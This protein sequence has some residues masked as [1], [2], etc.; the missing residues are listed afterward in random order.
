MAEGFLRL[1]RAGFTPDPPYAVGQSVGM[2]IR[3]RNDGDTDD[4]FLVVRDALAGATLFTFREPFAAGEQ[5]DVLF[6]VQVP[7]PNNAIHQWVFEAGHLGPAGDA[8][9]TTEIVLAAVGSL[10]NISL[11][12]ALD[13]AQYPQHDTLRATIRA[14][15]DGTPILG[16]PVTLSIGPVGA[17]SQF[18]AAAETGADGVAIIEVPLAVSLGTYVA[19]AFG[20]VESVTTV[21]S[22][23][24]EFAVTDPFPYV[25]VAGVAAAV[26]GVL[27]LL[28]APLP[29]V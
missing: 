20:I 4:G 11:T 25:L 1:I 3:M 19:R 17:T 5:K 13:R 7:G 16:M 28:F 12:L 18:V 23:P 22:A 21:E 6:T 8:I 15:S 29:E 27:A 14:M 2:V 26:V 24:V 9:D 10:P